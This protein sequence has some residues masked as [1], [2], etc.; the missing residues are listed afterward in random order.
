M[1]EERGKKPGSIRG[2]QGQTS[3]L[4]RIKCLIFLMVSCNSH[5]YCPGIPELEGDLNTSSDLGHLVE[6]KKRWTAVQGS[7]G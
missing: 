6:W 5:F 7:Q 4:D 1:G 3:F 2:R